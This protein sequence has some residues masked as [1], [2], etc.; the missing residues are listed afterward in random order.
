MDNTLDAS[1]TTPARSGNKNFSKS[2]RKQTHLP[3]KITGFKDS[4]ILY[5]MTE[6]LIN[7]SNGSSRLLILPPAILISTTKDLLSSTCQNKKM[8]HQW[9]ALHCPGLK[10]MSIALMF[11]YSLLLLNYLCHHSLLRILLSYYMWRGDI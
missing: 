8:K 3:L 9:V 1:S 11:L 5:N 7:Y 4:N 6:L 2:P 10:L